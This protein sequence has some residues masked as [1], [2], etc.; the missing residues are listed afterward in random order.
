MKQKTCPTLSLRGFRH[1]QDFKQINHFFCKWLHSLHQ[2]RFKHL[3]GGQHCHQ[4]L[5]ITNQGFI[6]RV[7]SL[8]WNYRACCRRPRA[9]RRST[10]PRCGRNS[11]SI[12]T[13][14]AWSRRC[15]PAE[16]R[17][18]RA[19]ALAVIHLKSPHMPTF[20]KV[21]APANQCEKTK[22]ES[23]KL[24]TKV[25]PLNHQFRSQQRT[26]LEKP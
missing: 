11:V 10:S 17:S 19:S 26:G 23:R 16:K 6:R 8:R 15:W 18:E 5:V 4:P 13:T 3:P 7:R 9:P 20:K 24:K 2:R 21:L 22:N 14:P 1:V 12:G 25:Q